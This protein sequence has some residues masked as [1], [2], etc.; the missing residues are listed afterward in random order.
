VLTRMKTKDDHPG[1]EYVP[2]GKVRIYD[3][4]DN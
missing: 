1:S 2:F 3:A 4:P